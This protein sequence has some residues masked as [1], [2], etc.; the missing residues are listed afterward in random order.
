M[1]GMRG[2]SIRD[3]KRRLTTRARKSHDFFGVA[4]V[5]ALSSWLNGFIEADATIAAL[6]IG[7]VVAAAVTFVVLRVRASRRDG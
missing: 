1:P 6:L 5:L 2:R 3:H 4:R 7:V